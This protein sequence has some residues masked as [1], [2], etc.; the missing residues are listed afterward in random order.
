MFSAVQ[1]GQE[2]RYHYYMYGNV[3]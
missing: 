3:L 2:W 1:C